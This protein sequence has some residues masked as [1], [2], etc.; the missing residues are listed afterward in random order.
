MEYIDVTPPDVT[1]N[2]T[3]LVPVYT[4]HPLTRR[5]STIERAVI[6]IGGEDRSAWTTFGTVWSTSDAVRAVHAHTVVVTPYFTCQMDDGRPQG[7]TSFD[8][9]GWVTGHWAWRPRTAYRDRVST[10]SAMDEMILKMKRIFP[11][12][13]HIV[14]AGYSAGGELVQRYAIF[15]DLDDPSLRLN[16]SFRYLVGA[17]SVYLYPTP[18]RPKTERCRT[19]SRC[20]VDSRKNFQIPTY[21]GCPSYNDYR[22]GLEQIDQNS[23][24]GS[25][26][27][28]ALR[29]AKRFPGRDVTYVVGEQDVFMHDLDTGCE[30]QWQGS[31]RVTRAVLY[32]FYVKHVLGGDHG[33]VIA[34]G[35]GHS[36]VEMFRDE[37]WVSNTF[38]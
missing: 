19:L 9:N 14:L 31:N 24:Y 12:L 5:N 18:D 33:L 2:T 16:L 17:P 3:Y 15:N 20:I 26:R 8:C 37:N 28:R 27:G 25:Q 11:N 22:Y 32:Y 23:A 7:E 35:L 21:S 29:A 38:Y 34:K 1:T 30:A 4:S 36:M 6:V 10:Y 13:L